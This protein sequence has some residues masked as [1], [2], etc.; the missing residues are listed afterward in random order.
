MTETAAEPLSP[1]G[2]ANS[3]AEF[4]GPSAIKTLLIPDSADEVR[5]AKRQ[6][7]RDQC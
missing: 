5:G 4:P 7:L 3:T 1:P 6:R 2:S